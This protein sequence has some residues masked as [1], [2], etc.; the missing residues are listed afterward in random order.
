MIV[1]VLQHGPWGGPGVVGRQLVERGVELDVR[2]V[3][4]GDDVPDDPPEALIVLGGQMCTD[5]KAAYPFLEKETV[6]LGKCV[7]SETPTLGICLGAQLLAEATGGSVR[8]DVP[9]IGFPAV[10]RTQAGREDPVLS[11]FTDG[12]PTFNAHRDFIA[13]GPDAVVLAESDRAPVHAFR[14]GPR[15]YGL[16]FHPEMDAPQVERY[17]SADQPGAYLR[18]HGCEPS[19]LIALAKRHD[20]DHVQMGRQLADRWLAHVVG[21]ADTRP[22]VAQ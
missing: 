18:R 17:A 21:L 12:T 6:L 8:H 1:T 7:A 13:A 11:A 5:E 16:Q 3:Y 20:A 9:E 2:K 4:D 14:V 10:R 15:A 22:A 19:N